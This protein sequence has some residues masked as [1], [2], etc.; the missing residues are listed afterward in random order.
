MTALIFNQSQRR[1]LVSTVLLLKEMEFRS[2][3]QYPKLSAAAP[4]SQED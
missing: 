2:R 4:N 1:E 3:S